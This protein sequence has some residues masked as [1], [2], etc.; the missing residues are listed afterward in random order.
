MNTGGKSIDVR[1]N[2]TEKRKQVIYDVVINTNAALVLF[3]MFR[4]IDIRGGI[5]WNHYNWPEHL[6]YTGHTD[7][8]ILYNINEVIVEECSEALLRNTLDELIGIGDIPDG[9]TPFP[10]MCLRTIKSREVPII[11]FICISWHGKYNGVSL[12]RRE[13]EFQSML[14]YISKLSENLALPVILAG[15]FNVAITAIAIM[16]RPPLVLH[17]YTPTERQEPRIVDFYISSESLTMTDINPLILERE[18][19][20]PEVLSL[21]NHDPVVSFVSTEAE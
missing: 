13:S 9:F 14:K 1:E 21:F 7:A 10:R 16:V 19:D 4:W 15:N 11:E 12:I 2:P 5:A 3:Q 17:R 20:V 18:T 6:Q 8:S